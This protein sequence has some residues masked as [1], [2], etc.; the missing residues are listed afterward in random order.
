MISV[1]N[2]NVNAIILCWNSLSRKITKL[3]PNTSLHFF[4]SNSSAGA[5][6]SLLYFCTEIQFPLTEINVI[7]EEK[8]LHLITNKEGYKLK[9]HFVFRERDY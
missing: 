1:R 4:I 8:K 3:E 2:S 6:G 7:D 9:Y 5:C